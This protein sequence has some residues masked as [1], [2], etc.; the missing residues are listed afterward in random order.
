MRVKGREI[1]MEDYTRREFILGEYG[2][3][4]SSFE[5]VFSPRGA[6][7]RPMRLFNRI[8]GERSRNSQSLGE[9]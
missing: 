7:G 5:A 6:D 8:T 3:Q 1:A 2:G 4:L 9:I